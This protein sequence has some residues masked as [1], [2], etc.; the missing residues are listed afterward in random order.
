MQ[1][2]IAASAVSGLVHSLR[3]FASVRGNPKSLPIVPHWAI[4]E[5]AQQRPAPAVGGLVSQHVP[6]SHG[7]R[8]QAT[9][10]SP[11]AVGDPESFIRPLHPAVAQSKRPA[12][13]VVAVE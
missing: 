7:K 12:T 5:V 9:S 4:G 6:A 13:L 10:S 11:G 2:L 8:L 1:Y 3:Q